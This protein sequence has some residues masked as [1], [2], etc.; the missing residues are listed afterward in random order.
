MMGMP[1]SSQSQ[2]V[3]TWLHSTYAAHL[4]REVPNVCVRGGFSFLDVK[5]VSLSPL[6]Y[7]SHFKETHS[8]ST[9]MCHDR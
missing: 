5:V 7:H 9:Q 6:M 8:C 3:L 4:P 1:P 2:D